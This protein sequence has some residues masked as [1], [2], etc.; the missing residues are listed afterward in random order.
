ML[1]REHFP[2]DITPMKARLHNK[3]FDDDNWIYE[4]KF[5]GIRC[6]VK[7]HNDNVMLHSRNNKNMDGTYPE[8]K[9]AF[10]SLALPDCIIDGEIVAFERK[11]TSFSRLQHRMNMQKPDKRLID[12]V[13]VYFYCFD[14]LHLDGKDLRNETLLDRKKALKNTIR[15]KDP[16]RYTVHRAGDGKRYLKEACKKGW[17]GIIAKKRDSKYETTRSHSWLKLKCSKGQEFVIGGYTDPQ[18]ERI[19]FG[20][21]LIGYYETEELRFA[22]SVGTGFDDAFLDEFSDKLEKIEKVTP[23]FEDKVNIKDAHF[24]QPKYVCEVN[25]TEWTKDN[26]LRHPRFKGLRHDKKPMEV[27]KES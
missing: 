10:D 19:G 16:I 22:G 6:L 4:R 27:K 20:A 13:P 18:G 15:Y 23:P 8:L 11:A 12:E 2:K 17:E 5:D 1:M 25:F 24:V 26:K 21:L 7:I 3:A 9:E 14:L